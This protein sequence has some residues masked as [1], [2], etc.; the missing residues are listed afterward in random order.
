MILETI[1]GVGSLTP[2][3]AYSFTDFNEVNLGKWILRYLFSKLIDE[4]IKRDEAHRLKLND[5][6]EKR[7][8]AAQ[9]NP[10]MS[11]S[12]PSPATNWESATESPV[13]TPRANGSQYPPPTPGIGIGLA[14]PGL[15]GVKEEGTSPMSPL[16]KRLS[17]VSRPSVDKDDYFSNAIGSVES[18]KPATT[19]ATEQPPSDAKTSTENGKEKEKEKEKEKGDNGKSQATPFGKKFRM[20]MSFGSK[21]LGRS[22]ST[23]APEKPAVVDERAEESESSSNHEKEFDDSFLGVV[24]KIQN[25]YEKQLTETPEKFVET[26]IAPSLAND[27]PVLKLPSGTKVI[28]QEE[29]SGG[30]AELYR[31][32]VETVGADA[33]TIEQCAPMWLG[34]VLLLNAIPQKDPI[35]VS[36]VLHPWQDSLPSIATADGN[37]RLNANRMLRVKKILAYVAERIDPPADPENPDP[38]A[39]RPE[40]YLEL[41]CND[42]VS[43]VAMSSPSSPHTLTYF[44]L[45]P[46]SMSLAT[47]RAHIWKGGNDIVLYYKANGKK[48]IP[49]PPPPAPEPEPEPA[50]TE[51]PGIPPQPTAVAA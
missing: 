44:Q 48:E 30:S 33:D 13:T 19:P 15:P 26:R 45:L 3:R 11:I 24:Q 20:G 17:H 1:K 36:F 47:L 23:T 21:K 16:D 49:F 29:T 6:V 40:E 31:G 2:D 41:Y 46:I 10:P 37:N 14:T 18:A 12:L 8:A 5:A 42:Q 4:E 43:H 9:A 28:I 34:E 27:T 39:L 35:K 50:E 7:I 51:A 38:D 25:E 22:A 32:T